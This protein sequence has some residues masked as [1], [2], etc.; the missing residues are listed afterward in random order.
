[1]TSA[2]AGLARCSSI[3]TVAERLAALRAVELRMPNRVALDIELGK[4]QAAFGELRQ[5]ELG[6]LEAELETP[7]QRLAHRLVELELAVEDFRTNTRPQRA[8][9]HVENDAQ[10]FA[11]E[12]AALSILARC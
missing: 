7:L 2:D 1:M 5:V 3:A 12:L 9:P 6:A 8:G 10:T 4:L 11:D